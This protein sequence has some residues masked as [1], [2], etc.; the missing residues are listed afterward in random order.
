MAE[1]HA[2]Q[3]HWLAAAAAAGLAALLATSSA[4]AGGFRLEPGAATRIDTGERQAYTT[5]T[6][7]NPDAVAGRLALEAPL[8]QV[9]DIPAGG[10]AELYGAYGR[11]TI[12]V[13]NT[14]GS[15]LEIVTRYQE[16]WRAP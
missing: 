3:S 11:S 12:A 9:I 8:N 15:R 6:I 5:I 1:Y 7:S 2:R 13:T 10:R 4:L 14:G 16:T